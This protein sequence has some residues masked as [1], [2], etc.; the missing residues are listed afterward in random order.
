MFPQLPCFQYQGSEQ[1]RQKG[2]Q[3]AEITLQI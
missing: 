1:D 2:K 3:A